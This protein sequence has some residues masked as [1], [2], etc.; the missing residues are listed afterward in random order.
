MERP[1]VHDLETLRE[2]RKMREA[3]K[4]A[5]SFP[6]DETLASVMVSPVYTCRP[7]ARIREVSKEMSRRQVSSAVAVNE[8]GE[9]VGV[10]TERDILNKIMAVDGLDMEKI[11]VSDVM[12]PG[13]VTLGPE[14]TVY[15]ALSVLSARGIKHLPEDKKENP[16]I[17]PHGPILTRRGGGR[18]PGRGPPPRRHRRAAGRMKKKGFRA[19]SG[20]EAL[21]RRGARSMLIACREA[22]HVA[23][24][25]GAICVAD[26]HLPV[27]GCAGTDRRRCGISRAPETT[28]PVSR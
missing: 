12:T 9:P 16:D 11:L 20:P 26:D 14:D 22:P 23:F 18:A 4:A 27:I 17:P 8:A 7:S 13:P 10:L 25:Q 28:G 6:Y 3:L 5:E 15:R 19:V 21:S 2:L 24:R 1:P